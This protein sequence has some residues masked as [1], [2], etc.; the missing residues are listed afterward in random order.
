MPPVVVAIGAFTQGL[1][2]AAGISGAALSL[3][4]LA[5]GGAYSLGASVG[6]ALAGLFGSA[7]GLGTILALGGAALSALAGRP[8]IPTPALPSAQTQIV[9]TSTGY[10]RKGWGTMRGGGHLVFQAVKRN[11]PLWSEGNGMMM[12]VAVADGPISA[13]T[14]Y[15]IDGRLC[16]VDGNLRATSGDFADRVFFNTRIGTDDQ[17]A[18]PTLLSEFPDE[19][20]SSWR[21]VGTALVQAHFQ[22]GSRYY[23]YIPN[24]FR[25]EVSVVGDFSPVYDPREPS[26]DPDDWINKTSW[27]HSRNAALIILDQ[28][29]A[30]RTENGFAIP[31]EFLDEDSFSAA[32][33]VCDVV[34]AGPQATTR[35]QWT[36]DGWNGYSEAPASV[37]AR[38]MSACDGEFYVTAAGKI[39]LRVGGWEEPAITL[40]DDDIARIKPSEGGYVGDVKTVVRSK[41][42]SPAHGYIEMDAIE[43]AHPNADQIGREVAALDFIMAS[44]HGLCR[45]LQKINAHLMNADVGLTVETMFSGLRVMGERYVRIQSAING[46]DGTFRIEGGVK[47]LID[48][49]GYVMGVTFGCVSCTESDISYDETVDGVAPPEVPVEIDNDLA[50]AVPTM[51]TSLSGTTLTVTLSDLEEG[52]LHRVRLIPTYDQSQLAPLYSY[53]EEGQS[54]ITITDLTDGTVYEVAAQSFTGSGRESAYSDADDITVMVDT[55]APGAPTAVS[56]QANGAGQIR[57]DYTT[58]ASGNLARAKVYVSTVND[59]ASAVLAGAFIAA[60]STVYQSLV[61][62][63]APGDYYVWVSLVNGSNA[64]SVRVAASGTPVTVT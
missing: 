7:G 57:A 55:V 10:R 38:M 25:T 27:S 19:T 41:Y 51:A 63:L 30:P 42:L 46:I 6:F 50:P 45:H 16:E 43:Y 49:D 31:R 48:E 56:A 9:R 59:S 32:A 1:L 18:F 24:G 39:G 60:Q 34:V 26:H 40:T 47:E 4:G 28:L 11:S 13:Y 2:A 58:S 36:L 61:G 62:D 53:L 52:N 14:G 21:G 64:E 29:S 23:V 5:A 17:V 3:T 12:I 22:C 15:Y 8:E 37:L 33:D 20:D 35:A 44:D 54:Q